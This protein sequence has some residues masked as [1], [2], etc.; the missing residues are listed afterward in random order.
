MLRPVGG[1]QT[2]RSLSPAPDRP[3]APGSAARSTP[4]RGWDEGSFLISAAPGAGKTHPALVFAAQELRAGRARRVAVVCPTSPLTRQWARA[5]ARVGLHLLPDAPALRPPGDFQGVALTYARV[6]I[7]AAEYAQTCS[8]GHARHR[9]RGAPPRRGP[10]VGRRASASR[11]ATARRWL[12][13]SGTPFRSDQTRDPGRRA[14][15]AASRVPDVSYTYADA[16]RDGVCRPVAFVPVRRDAA[17]AV[18]RRRHRDV[19]RRGAHR[20]A[21]PAAATGRRSRPSC[22]TAC[23]GSCAPRT[24]KLIEVRAGRPPRRGRPRRHRRLRARAR[25][26]QGAA[27]DHRRRS[28]T[29]VL[30]TE[31]QRAPQARGVPP[32]RASRG[33]SR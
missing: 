3:S 16:V 2:A 1:P 12:L 30:H 14:T 20:R 32:R 10:R 11:S 13:L 22:P 31:A 25:G 27:R 29:V 5:A 24:R 28:P 23:R 21:R 7:G 9:R 19:V 18:R 15:T 8:P 6:A 17:V 4:W 33:S 26:R